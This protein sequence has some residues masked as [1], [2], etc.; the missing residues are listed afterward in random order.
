[1]HRYSRKSRA[2]SISEENAPKI[3]QGK[4]SWVRNVF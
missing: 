3:L 2:R 1:M 4:G